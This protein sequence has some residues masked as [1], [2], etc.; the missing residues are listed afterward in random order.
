MRAFSERDA[1]RYPRFLASLS[2]AASFAAELAQEAPPSLD[3]PRAGELW[4][5]FKTGRR[6][7]AL[8]REQG[9]AR[10]AL[11]C[12][13][14][15]PTS[16]RTTSRPRRC[17]R[18]LP[19]AAS[20]ARTSDRGPRAPAATLILA[21]RRSRPGGRCAAC[22]CGAARA[23]LAAAMAAAATR[24]ARGIRVGAEVARH[25]G[26]TDGGRA[27]RARRAIDCRRRRVER[28]PAAHAARTGRSAGSIRRC[29]C[30]CGTGVPR[31]RSRRSTSWSTAF[32]RSPPRTAC[33]PR[34]AS[35]RIL[36]APT[37]DTRRARVR[38]L[39]VRRLLG[40]PWLECVIPTL[41][42][43]GLAPAGQHVLVNLR[44]VRAATGCGADRGPR[45]GTGSS[46]RARGAAEHAPGI[47]SRIVASEVLTPEDL[48][49]EHGLT[50]GHVHH[51]EMALDQLFVMRPLLGLRAV[52][53]ADPRG[54]TCAAPARIPAAAS[55]APTARTPRGSSATS[56]PRPAG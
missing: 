15:W 10:A 42:G 34:Q 20:S 21:P 37:I 23:R 30:A 35:R 54:C 25:V 45:H 33:R 22:S 18:R 50:G 41:A 51:G 8:G 26:D 16:R 19:R 49:R 53:H 44:A 43:S 12:R 4:S 27:A 46:R 29:S 31:A 5:L 52:P 39:E 2:V 3:A 55:P 48:E 40:R 28:R 7:R 36:I 6:F 14:R 9:A 13:W 38:R 24:A 56:G 1:A 17:A 32:P 47:E 11:G